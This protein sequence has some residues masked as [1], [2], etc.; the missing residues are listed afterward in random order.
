VPL[1]PHAFAPISPFSATGQTYYVTK[2]ETIL[3]LQMQSDKEAAVIIPSLPP[4]Y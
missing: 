3:D 4:A 2:E 1:S